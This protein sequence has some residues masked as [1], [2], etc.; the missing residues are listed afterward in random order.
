MIKKTSLSSKMLT[1]ASDSFTNL[2]TM[3]LQKKNTQQKMGPILST[4]FFRQVHR[5]F[6]VIYNQQP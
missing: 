5:L 3:N 2:E 4:Y 1:Y 6:Q